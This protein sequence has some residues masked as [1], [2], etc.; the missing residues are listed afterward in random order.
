MIKVEQSKIVLQNIENQIQ[1]LPIPI[2]AVMNVPAK[3]KKYEVD[4]T[5]IQ[6][7]K[8]TLISNIVKIV[9]VQ[10]M[11]AEINNQIQVLNQKIDNFNSELDDFVQM[12][13]AYKNHLKSPILKFDYHH[14]KNQ[15]NQKKRA[16]IM[17]N[18]HTHALK[19]Q[20]AQYEQFIDQIQIDAN[21]LIK[22]INVISIDPANLNYAIKQINTLSNQMLIIK[23]QINQLDEDEDEMIDQ[24][25]Q[26]I[27]EKKQKTIQAQKIQ[28]KNQ[29]PFFDV[30]QKQQMLDKKIQK[31][32]NHHIK[33]DDLLKDQ[34]VQYTQL[35]KQIKDDLEQL[36]MTEMDVFITEDPQTY[37]YAIKQINALANQITTITN[38]IDQSNRNE[39]III[40]QINQLINNQKKKESKNI[41]L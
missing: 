4:L 38:H 17:L 33:M 31:L 13:Q 18:I 7:L 15:I 39:L 21:Q 30:D 2:K 6:H 32:S 25:D 36:T 20:I 14:K 37:D 34:I 24:I 12:L 5:D 41:D 22:K 8:E 40:N 26:L 29:I 23:N 1:H 35:I 16:L 3:L 11:T 10:D 28:L 19:D 27:N 9:H